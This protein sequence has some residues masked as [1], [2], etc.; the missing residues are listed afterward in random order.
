VSIEF[1]ISITSK[2]KAKNV[3]INRIA[4]YSDEWSQTLDIVT[5]TTAVN[6]DKITI[7]N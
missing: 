1:R 3:F 2:Y 6:G 7:T 4:A 5:I